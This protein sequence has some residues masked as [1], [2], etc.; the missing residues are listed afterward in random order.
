MATTIDSRVVEMRFDNADFEKNANATLVALKNLDKSLNGLDEVK[1]LENI[2]KAAKN[3]DF[4]PAEKSVENL[5]SKFTA[6]E[7]VAVTALVNITNSLMNLGQQTIKSLTIDQLTA[8]WSKYAEKT[9]AVQVIMGATAD[10]FT[11]TGKQMEY[12][13]GQLDKLNWFTDETSYNFLD[14]VNNIGKFTANKIPLDQAVTSMQGIALWGARSGA[15]V[16]QVSHAMYNLSQAIGVGAV[17]LQDWKSIEN[18][19][20]ATA[21]FKQAAMDAAV[22]IGTL[23]KSSDGLYT[24]LDGGEVSITNFREGL[25]EGWLSSEVLVKT[26]DKYGAFTDKLNEAYNET[27]I[28]TTNLLGYIEDYKNETLDLEAAAR[29]EGVAVED[30]KNWMDVLSDSTYDFGRAA[31]QAGQEAKTFQEAIDATKDAVSTG[32]M[33]TFELIFGNYEQAKK[34]WTGVS[35]ELWNIF[36]SG[37]EARNELLAEWNKL[38]GR[39]RLF[40]GIA[41]VWNSI[42]SII[43][44]VRD[45]FRTVFPPKTAANL[46]NATNAFY[47]FS[48]QLIPSEKLLEGIKTTFTGLFSVLKVGVNIIK[49]V[50]HAF[51]PLVTIFGKALAAVGRLAISA[52]NF[53][54]PILIGAANVITKVIFGFSNFINYILTA[55]SKIPV[56][57]IATTALNAALGLI[58]GAVALAIQGLSKLP[59]IGKG[60][61]DKLVGSV[62]SFIEKIRSIKIVNDVFTTLE[63]AFSGVVTKFKEFGTSIHDT[64]TKLVNVIKTGGI[65]AFIKEIMDMIKGVGDKVVGFFKNLNF[66]DIIEA[67]KNHISGAGDGLKGFLDKLK[68]FAKGITPAKLAAIGFSIAVL[69]LANSFSKASEAFVSIGGL[70]AELKKRLVTPFQTLIPK[71][72]P[73]LQFSVA[74]IAIAKALKMLSEV[75]AEDLK[76]VVASV[77][78]L[79]VVV[80]GLIGILSVVT[81]KLGGGSKNL[82]SLGKMLISFGAGIGAMAAGMALLNASGDFTNV[83]EKISA[84]VSIIV[85]FGAMATIMSKFAGGKLIAPVMLISF[86]ASMTLIMTSFSKLASLPTEGLKEKIQAMIMIMGAMALLAAGLGAIRIGSVLGVL[87]LKNVLSDLLPSI[88]EAAGNLK[89]DRSTLATIQEFQPLIDSMII[90]FGLVGTTLALA[91]SHVANNLSKLTAGLIGLALSITLM[92]KVAESIKKAEFSYD[93]INKAILFIGSMMALF[94]II[95]H[96]AGGQDVGKYAIRLSVMIVSITAMV[97]ILSGLAVVLGTID[98]GTVLLKGVAT[99]GSLMALFAVIIAASGLARDVKPTAII[100]VVIGIV[101]LSTELLALSFVPWDDIKYALISIVAVMI[102]LAL[103]M[104]AMGKIKFD[105]A[106]STGLFGI[107]TILGVLAASLYALQDIPWEK[108]AS[109]AGAMGITMLAIGK[110][111]SMMGGATKG[112]DLKSALILGVTIA[113]ITAALKVLSNIPWQQALASSVGLSLVLIALGAAGQMLSKV[114]VD[115]KTFLG[116]AAGVGGIIA[117]IFA[118]KLLTPTLQEFATIPW[119][120]LAKAGATLLGLVTA[121]LVLSEVQAVAV[122]GA[123]G[124]IA[125]SAALLILMPALQSLEAINWEELGKAGA[126]LVAFTASLAILG[127]IGPMVLAA[128][129]ALLLLGGAFVASAIGLQ[130]LGPALDAIAPNVGLLPGLAL[131]LSLVAMAGGLMTGAVAG[132]L[133]GGAALLVLAKGLEVL[134]SVD[135]GGLAGNLVKMAGGCAVFAAGAVA[136]GASAPFMVL[137]AGGV[138]LLSGA[139]EIAYVAF[140]KAMPAIVAIFQKGVQGLSNLAKGIGNAILTPFKAVLSPILTVATGIGKFIEVGIRNG[141]GYHSPI[142]WL[143]DAGS[144]I[145][146]S[147]GIGAQAKEGE[148]VS[149]FGGIGQKI[150]GAITDGVGEGGSVMDSLFGSMEGLSGMTDGLTTSLGGLNIEGA[151]LSTILGQVGGSLDSATMGSDLFGSSLTNVANGLTTTHYA[152]SEAAQSIDALV[153]YEA[154]GLTATG[155]LANKAQTLSQSLLDMKGNVDLSSEGFN[156]LRTSISNSFNIFDE[157]GQKQEITSQQILTNMEGQINSISNWADNVAILADKGIDEGLLQKLVDMGPQGASYIEAFATMTTEQIQKA[158][159]L[160]QKS[161]TIPDE[162]AKIVADGLTAAAQGGVDGYTNTLNENSQNMVDAVNKPMEEGVKAVHNTWKTQSPSIVMKELGE[163]IMR[164]LKLGL[165]GPYK[166]QVMR[167]IKQFGDEAVKE[168]TRIAKDIVDKF[169]EAYKNAVSTKMIPAI[170]KSVKDM[171]DAFEKMWQSES[172]RIT[173]ALKNY[174]PDSE[175]EAIGK[176]LVQGMEKG[177]IDNSKL[178]AEAIKKAV[179]AAIAAGVAEAEINSPSRKA[180]REIGVYIPLGIAKGIE[181]ESPAVKNAVIDVIDSLGET[182]SYAGSLFDDIIDLDPVITPRLDLSYINPGLNAINRAF[183][184]KRLSGV[185]SGDIGNDDVSSNGNNVVFNQYNYSPKELSRLDIYRNTKNLLSAARG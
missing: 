39:T 65:K 24:T 143:I 88:I 12:V 179:K 173:E 137:A 68:E 66:Q 51:S 97:A 183:E 50:L 113:G 35:E 126:I 132:L 3:M 161:L 73:L 170:E 127:A 115:F 32:W 165:T 181:K 178:L 111:M 13:E 16:Q 69:A 119:Q 8:G 176:R 99:I 86:A 95:I 59:S 81:N 100:A 74:V 140:S 85:A 160:W 149:L 80:G 180:E 109:S 36:A 92:G 134:A 107:A 117:I 136:I 4:T 148:T 78:T 102:S 64:I 2:S 54:G 47:R 28:I 48:K 122:A 114:S 29:K 20:M 141:L 76:K 131:G 155:D 116:L 123:V 106:T 19:N 90:L 159:E 22:E 112:I 70:A 17:K 184:S 30:L 71:I 53:F 41:N 82:D 96:V 7:I 77:A 118:F 130:I 11:D 144:E 60:I 167:A 6:L 45:A 104:K 133:L 67:I 38:G 151:N 147:L 156:N 9:S 75:P 33:K 34:L 72:S 61:F 174:P 103:V 158:N 152:G 40:Q 87:L 177:I 145:L 26:L 157:L 14:M 121:M 166:A 23:T 101:I 105:P 5:K 168:F 108:L 89:I 153:G 10:Q 125:I 128:G 175:L 79:S 18:A 84:M 93:D 42:K 27:G 25:K 1:G 124:M 62:K 171:V 129:G 21:E 91:V 37:A 110:A 44:A 57:T 182:M 83:V 169:T 55:I 172:K 146:N 120:S 163:N 31:L 56:L 94:A 139:I 138:T 164:G 63:K 154:Q 52:G 142:K 49:G 43:L 58:G 135:T 15:N 185:Y 46:M 150:A 98:D 162:A